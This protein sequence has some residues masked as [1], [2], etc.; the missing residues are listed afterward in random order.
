MSPAPRDSTLSAE[1]AA[2]IVATIAEADAAWSAGDRARAIS[3]LTALAERAPTSAPVWSRLG[4]CALEAGQSDAA[5]AYLRNAV[6]HAPDDSSA[7][8]NLGVALTRLARAD[9]GIAAYRRALALDPVA[10]GA[11]VNLANAL[12]QRDDVDGAVAELEAARRI[13]PDAHEVLNNLG[14]LYKDQ[15]RFDDA[16]AAYGAARRAWPDF[17]VAFSNLL[18]LTKLS[19][20]H[21]PADI[22]ALH[23]AFAERFEPGWQAAYV[24]AE[25]TPDANRRLRVCYVSPDCHS[26]LPSFVEPVLRRHD[27]ARFDVFAYF[28]NPQPA[29][30]LA[31]IAPITSRIMRGATDEEVAKWVRADGIDILIDIAGHT[32]H[33]RLGVFGRKP[34]PVQ[35]TWLDYLNT[36]GL[37]AIDYRLTDA[38]ADPPG[39][40][41]A[42]HSETLLRLS[43]A[44]WCWNPPGA[45]PP[46]SSLPAARAGHLMLG[47]FNAYSKLTDATLA[48]WARVLAAVP[49]ARLVVVGV[50]PGAATSRIEAAFGARVRVLPRLAPDAFREAIADAD[51]ALDPL[52]FSGATTTLEALWRGVPVVTRTGATSA[53]RSSASILCA[54][55]LT[56]WIA[57]DDEGYVAIVERAARSLD[58]LGELRRELPGIVQSSSLCDAAR[59]IVGLE[60]TLRE[61]WRIWCSGRQNASASSPSLAPAVAKSPADADSARR[62]ALDAR[63][64]RLDTALRE[65]RGAEAVADACELVDD[66]PAWKAAHRAYL[67]ALLAWANTQPGLVGR[68]FAPPPPIARRP[69]VSALVCSIDR[70]RFDKVTASYRARFAGFALEIVGVHDARSLAEGYNRAAAR[71]TGDILLFSHDDIELM[72]PDFAVRLAAHL[73]RYDGVG[74]AG[75]S[76]VAGPRWTDAGPRATHGHILHPPLAGGT[77][78]LL[79]AWGFQRPVCEDIRL[80]DG[81]FIAVR[82]HVWESVRFD[83]DRYDGFHLYDLDFTSRASAAGA[84]LAVPADL[85]V[86]HASK[87]RYGEAWRRYARRFAEA[88]G[89]DSS[90]PAPPPGLQARLETREQIDLLRAAMVHFRYGA[91]RARRVRDAAQR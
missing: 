91:P 81:A 84:R 57:D 63:V 30:T 25:T 7:W 44:Q 13:A 75:A 80:L 45:A 39:T 71:A 22:F 20:R 74:A 85:L 5:H 42:L 16:F 41:D 58:A 9:E 12:A 77:G 78:V 54:L 29:A 33:N 50:P 2:T 48:L 65:G 88:A 73:E 40:S 32:G 59:F 26:A 62:F 51:I 67:Q 69:K 56:N 11:R 37:A 36:T 18:A 10:V 34:A 35:I 60:Q 38:V 19:T 87:G 72:T 61:A 46:S 49:Q 24:P 83:P 76:Q 89:L 55:G 23:R 53:S 64:A 47:S 86:F 70:A 79:M 68:V 52:P 1:R 6:T 43:P 4:A 27:R 90:A 28:N 15:G 14:N 8:T 3:M 31:R 21:T 66:E 17:R 82:R